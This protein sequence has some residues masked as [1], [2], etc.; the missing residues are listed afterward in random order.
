[1]SGLLASAPAIW[2]PTLLGKVALLGSGRLTAHQQVVLRPGHVWPVLLWCHAGGNG[3]LLESEAH[4]S[5]VCD[6]EV[7]STSVLPALGPVGLGP[8]EA[9]QGEEKKC[10]HLAERLGWWVEHIYDQVSITCNENT[11]CVQPSGSQQSSVLTFRMLPVPVLKASEKQT[12]LPLCIV[13]LAFEFLQKA[14]VPPL[15]LSLV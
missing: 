4:Y 13:L 8:K 14:M 12:Q 11:S 9:T 15:H 3:L 10:V 2:P 5:A 1:M 7:G 6:G